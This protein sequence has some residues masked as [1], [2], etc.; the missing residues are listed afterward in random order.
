MDNDFYLR[1]SI[2]KQKP[3]ET[4]SMTSSSSETDLW[5]EK[6]FA[7]SKRFDERLDDSSGSS[8]SYDDSDSDS[9]TTSSCSEYE[10]REAVPV[11]PPEKPRASIV[12]IGGTCLP[13]ISRNSEK[14]V[15]LKSVLVVCIQ[16]LHGFWP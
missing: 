1:R 13:A 10:W 8:S 5:S 4:Y 11:K 7:S 3:K 2:W 12:K 15:P 6:Q 16:S 14:L 9:S